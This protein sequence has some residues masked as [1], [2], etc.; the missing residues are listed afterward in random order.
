[1]KPEKTNNFNLLND[2]WLCIST[3]FKERKDRLCNIWQEAGK[4]HI[5]KR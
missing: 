4:T 2:F 5:H 1:M 3:A